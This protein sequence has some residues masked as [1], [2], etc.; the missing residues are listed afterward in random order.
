MRK[1]WLTAGVG[2]GIGAVMLLVSGYSALAETSGYDVYKAALKNTKAQTSLSANVDLTITDNGTKLLVGNAKIKLSHELNTGSVEANFDNG[3]QKH[4]LNV[5]RQDGKIIFK[6]GD[7]AVYQVMEHNTSEWQHEGVSQNPPKEVEQVFDALMGNMRELATVENE[8]DGGKQAALHLTGSEIP[9]VANVLG[10]LVVS[11]VVG[12]DGWDHG[13]W[14]HAG[15]SSFAP[16]DMKVNLPKLT[17]NIKIEKINLD[18][19][20]NPDHVLEQQTAEINITGTDDSGKN[21]GLN[22]QVH[23]DFSDFNQ[24]TP[25]R[26]DLTGKQTLEIQHHGA[27]HGWHH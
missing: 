16:S 19:R 15:N 17:D 21:H 9:A 11:K 20:I 27:K 3:T 24:T 12:G 7:Q 23:V 18:A 14:N 10:T 26:I 2:F 5:F 1:K 6:S 4:T 8:S 25:E 13:K 22:I